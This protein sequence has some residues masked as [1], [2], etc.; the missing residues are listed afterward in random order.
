MER[1]YVCMLETL[2]AEDLALEELGMV[3]STYL[4]D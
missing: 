2:Q 4:R 1:G 3:R